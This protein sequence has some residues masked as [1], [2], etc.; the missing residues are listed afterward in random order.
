M[1]ASLLSLVICVVFVANARADFYG[2]GPGITI[3]D[4]TTQSSTINAVNL[5]GPNILTFD[6]VTLTVSTTHT[7]RG[8]LT[9]TLTAPNGE[10]V[11][12]FR[13]PGTSGLGS[14]GDW[15]AGNY[16]FVLSG[17]LAVPNNNGNMSPGT[18]NI[19][20]NSG[21]TQG[22]PAPDPDTYAIFTGDNLNGLWTFSITDS[23]A[24]DTGAISGWG[25][26]ITSS[27]IP[28]P[29]SFWA[30]GVL[31]LAGLFGLRLRRKRA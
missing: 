11:Q 25:M 22:T 6:S 15:Q 30:V 4:L 8:D 27:A 7:W 12:L 9:L 19:T 31:G 13:R 28:E 17:G 23:A 21:S 16:T 1:K 18:Y 24:G 5:L 3:V 10:S 29:S 14:S 2:T 26:N 20:N